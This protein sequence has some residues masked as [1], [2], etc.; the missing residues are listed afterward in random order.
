MHLLAIEWL[1]IKKYRTFWILIGLFAILLPLWN[2]GMNQQIFFSTGGKGDVGQIAFLKQAYTFR[3]VWD[4]IGFW[5]SFFVFFITVLMIIITT[6]EYSF[7]TSRQNVIDGWSRMQFYHAKWLMVIVL[8][9]F[10]T[11]FSFIT[12]FIFGITNSSIDLF[13][14]HIEKMFYL[15]ILSINYFGFGL[16][17]ALLLKR[18]GITIGL[19]FLYAMMIETFL[20]KFINFRFDTKIGNYFP[21]QCSDELLPFSITEPITSIGNYVDPKN[22]IFASII[23]IVIYYLI[24]RWRLVKSDW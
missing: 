20:S 15:F 24:G 14:G 18:S 7:R 23:W 2:Y 5:A 6:N 8:S 11:V 9:V 4:N 17:I 22:Y 16:L 13:P 3:Y 21:L 19:F 1:K 10:T 12:G